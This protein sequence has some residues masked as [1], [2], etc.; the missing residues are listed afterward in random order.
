MILLPG[1]RNIKLNIKSSESTTSKIKT[2]F[3][4]FDIVE[5]STII[6]KNAKNTND[7]YSSP[8]YIL[9]FWITK[10][11]IRYIDITEI[12]CVKININIDGLPLSKSSQQQ[13]WPILG[14]ILPYNNVFIIGIYYGNEKPADVNDFLQD[15]VNEAIEICENGN[16]FNNRNIQCRNT[17][18]RCTSQIIYFMY[19]RSYRIFLSCTKCIIEGEYIKNR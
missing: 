6:F 14:S 13:F 10:C 7:T 1:L 11:Y 2:A 15:F 4:F 18:M 8:G 16:Y 9:S 3:L 12:I 17:D 5:R 19:K